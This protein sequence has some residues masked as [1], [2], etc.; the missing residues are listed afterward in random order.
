LGIHKKNLDLTAKNSNGIA[1]YSLYWVLSLLDYYQYSGKKAELIKFIPNVQ[2]K[3]SLAAAM[4]SKPN[5]G[6]YG[7][8]DRLGGGFEDA[9]CHE[10]REAYRMLFIETCRR[11]AHAMKTIHRSRLQKKYNQMAL[12]Y[13]ARIESQ[14]DWISHVGIFAASDAI[15]GGVPDI[16]QSRY[17]YRHVF[18]NPVA[19]ISFSPFNEYF[20]IRAMGKLNWTDQA[21]QTVLEDWGGQ[22]RYGGTTF[23]ECYWPSWNAVISKNGPIP[24]C[25]AGPTSLCHPWSSGCTTWLTQYVAGVRPTGPGFATVDIAPHMGRLLTSVSATAPTPHGAIYAS[26]N[27]ISGRA[28]VNIPAGVVARIAIPKAHR[29]VTSISVNGKLAWCGR[30]CSVKGIAAASNGRRRIYFVGVRP[31]R[32]TFTISYAG[33]PR[34]YIPRA[35]V[36]PVKV[37]GQD[38]STSGN[39]GGVFGKHGYVLFDYDGVGKS[40]EHL[41][42]YVQSVTCKFEYNTQWPAHEDDP[43]ALAP[44]PYNKGQRVAGTVH[45]GSTSWAGTMVINI[46]LK[47]PRNFQLAIYAVDFDRKARREAVEVHDLPSLILAAPVQVISHF[48]NGKYLVFDCHGSVRLR[49]DG[50]RGPNGIV[51]GLF[52]DR[53]GEWSAVPK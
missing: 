15:N 1:S 14:P 21:L 22:I 24:S 32:Y 45:S 49:V 38:V 31:G 17:L 39:W 52:F 4:F 11:F 23:F 37:V 30:F 8:D 46:K 42:S 51:S 35:L 13:I 53:P 7:W 27:V 44:N 20:I 6:F 5:I 26:F 12:K 9:D 10:A 25:Q 18:S 48:Q 3:L 47:H 16:A 36:Y 50:I 40:K 41:P 2:A 43:R 33:H 28:N 29:V 19:R 34:K